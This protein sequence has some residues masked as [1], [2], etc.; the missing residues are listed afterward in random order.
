MTEEETRDLMARF[1]RAFMKGDV[2][3]IV[4]CV[5]DDFEWRQAEGPE[6]PWGRIVK[7]TAQLRDAL[8]ERDRAMANLHYSDAKVEIC[9]ERVVGTFRI[10]GETADGAP[11]DWR[12]CDLYQIRDG[13]IAY[14]DSY[15]KRIIRS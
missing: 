8:A 12:G 1:G 15:W 3:G 11:A 14:K 9:G 6:V 4:A 2:E 7:G 5:T 10:S 13:K